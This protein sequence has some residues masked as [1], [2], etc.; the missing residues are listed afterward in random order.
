MRGLFTST[1]VFLLFSPRN[2][3]ASLLRAKVEKSSTATEEQS[4]KLEWLF[5][6]TGQSEN[7]NNSYDNY[8]DKEVP[9]DK[10]IND[11]V[12]FLR[13]TD[14]CFKNG[15]YS[16]S[17]CP[18]PPDCNFSGKFG[19]AKLCINRVPRQDDHKFYVMVMKC[20]PQWENCDK[21]MCGNISSDKGAGAQ[22]IFTGNK[23]PPND[24]KV[25]L[26]C[27][28]LTKVKFE[29]F[30]WTVGNT[31]IFQTKTTTSKRTSAVGA[32]KGANKKKGKKF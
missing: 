27:N 19:P 7:N 18:P 20:I 12:D 8:D 17:N 22:C 24:D 6:S 30:S 9:A 15:S 4:R 1:A 31:A 13:S 10:S 16:L 23:E 3:N 25:G 28:D 5:V 2:I 32:S 21:C 11:A 14:V 29:N 26:N